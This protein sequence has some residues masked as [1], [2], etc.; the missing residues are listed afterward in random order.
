MSSTTANDITER[1]RSDVKEHVMT[2]HRD[3]G[4]YRHLE[5]SKPGT[6]NYRFGLVTWPGYLA[7]Y[8][9]MGGY[10]FTR[11]RDMFEFFRGH[12]VNPSY[13]AEK[14]VASDRDGIKDWSEE[15]FAEAVREDSEGWFEGLDQ[16]AAKELRE[17]I[18]EG[19]SDYGANEYEAALWIN[20]FDHNGHQF[21]DFWA[22]DCRDYTHRFLWCLHAI[23]WGITRYDAG[24]GSPCE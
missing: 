20:G 18:E 12:R 10:M 21:H 15:R 7:Y 19:I 11:L 13:W 22:N 1:F 9:D 24:K 6:G 3:D 5:F 4:L 14:C 23:V 8:G 17:L 2:I 16:E